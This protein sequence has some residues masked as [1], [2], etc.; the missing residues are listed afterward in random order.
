MLTVDTLWKFYDYSPAFKYQT[1]W[2]RQEVERIF[3][4]ET[5]WNEN[6][7]ETNT[8]FYNALLKASYKLALRIAKAKMPFTIAE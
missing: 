8:K 6:S 3:R 7:T 5:K 4:E 2:T 1:Q